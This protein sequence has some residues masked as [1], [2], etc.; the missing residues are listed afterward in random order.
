M[1]HYYHFAVRRW[2]FWTFI[3][4]VLLGVYVLANLAAWE[5]TTPVHLR[6]ALVIGAMFWSLF[7]FVAWT[8]DGVEMSQRE[9]LVGHSLPPERTHAAWED[10]ARFEAI[11]SRAAE[12][13][14]ESHPAV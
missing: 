6:V 8:A 5:Q 11:R 3:A 12:Q 4:G 7:A 1:A 13:T 14:G 9:I 10:S 2:V